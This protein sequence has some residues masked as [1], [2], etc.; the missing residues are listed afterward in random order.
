MFRIIFKHSFKFQVMAD[1]CQEKYNLY[2]M[3][4]VGGKVKGKDRRPLDVDVAFGSSVGVFFD[5]MLS[6]LYL[7]LLLML[8][9][10]LLLL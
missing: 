1:Q 5:L 4:E 8:L 9:I 7:L 10:V 6:V 3:A 2:E